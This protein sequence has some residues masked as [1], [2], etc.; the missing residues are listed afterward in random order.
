[1]NARPTAPAGTT[2]PA[3]TQ[4]ENKAWEV[5][6]GYVLTG[7][8]STYAGVTPKAP[9]NWQNGTWGAWQAVA[10]YSDLKIDPKTFPLFASPLSNAAE[11]R[12]AGVGVNWYLTKAVRI[13]QDYFQT[14]FSNNAGPV[15]TSQILRQ[16]EKAFITRV[17][18]VF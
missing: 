10:R 2:V 3:K 13:T 8:D 16:D 12:A 15:S 4:L 6:A 7:E 1:L 11:A 17:Q 5:S 9:F 14:S 18:I